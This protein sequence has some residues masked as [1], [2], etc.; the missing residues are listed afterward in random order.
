MGVK[1][2]QLNINYGRLRIFTGLLILYIY[3]YSSLR[4]AKWIGYI[5][6]WNDGLFE[7]LNTGLWST[8]TQCN[9]IVGL[10]LRFAC[11][12]ACAHFLSFFAVIFFMLLFLLWNDFIFKK[13]YCSFVLGYVKISWIKLIVFR[14]QNLSHFNNMTN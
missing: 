11:D 5:Q 14:L 1:K 2:L 6:A 3:I 10:D 8:K 12:M 13:F 4:W 7:N 9:S